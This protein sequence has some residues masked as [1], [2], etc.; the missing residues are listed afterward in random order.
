VELDLRGVLVVE[1]EA[2]ALLLLVDKGLRDK[3]MLAAL[4]TKA[5]TLLL[6]ME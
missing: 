3:V 5:Q 6:L 1:Q 4:D 2:Q